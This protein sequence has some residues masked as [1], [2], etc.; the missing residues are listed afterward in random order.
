VNILRFIDPKSQVHILSQKFLE[1]VLTLVLYGRN[2]GT[3]V[4][5]KWTNLFKKSKPAP[6]SAHG[7]W[8]FFGKIALCMTIF[9]FYIDAAPYAAIVTNLKTGK[10]IAQSNAHKSVYPA[11]LTKMMTLYLTFEDLSKGKI[12]L[13][14]LFCASPLASKQPPSKWGVRPNERISVRQCI[15]ALSVKSSNDIAYVVAENIEKN[16]DQFVA[17]MNLKALQLG[18][19]NSSFRNPSG[20]H[21]PLQKTTAHDMAILMRAIC[22]HFPKYANFLGILSIQKGKNIVR[23]TNKLL[24]RVPGMRLGKT[25]FTL[26]SG[27][28]LAAT[29]HRG[30]KTIVSVVMGMP[31]TEHRNKLTAHL[32]ETFYTAPEKLDLAINQP[33]QTLVQNTLLAQSSGRSQL[34]KFLGPKKKLPIRMAQARVTMRRKKLRA[35]AISGQLLLAKAE[36]PTKGKPI[37]L[38][39]KPNAPRIKPNIQFSKNKIKNRSR[40][41]RNPKN[42]QS[43]LFLASNTPSKK[44]AGKNRKKQS[45][46]KPLYKRTRGGIKPLYKRTRGGT[47][48]K[49]V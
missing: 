33:N 32:I 20:W 48:E 44:R 25:G 5:Q 39:T 22:T 15:L 30:D 9:S 31:S 2:I 38:Y 46:C 36:T 43:I 45:L 4:G 6:R 27:F 17:R 23:N 47:K 3:L 14:T 34:A 42:S 8:Y 16:M 37:A 21:H 18:M 26:P 40:K 1:S 19:R 28:N 24:G 35:K 13:N 12:T 49:M 29:T 7:P 41:N 11:S 10:T